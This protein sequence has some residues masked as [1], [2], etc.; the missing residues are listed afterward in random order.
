[1]PLT[2]VCSLSRRISISACV[3]AAKSKVEK[4][5]GIATPG[6]FRAYFKTP[7]FDRLARA[8]LQYFLAVEEQ[9]ALSVVQRPLAE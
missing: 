2:M 9:N 8:C 7:S 4:G 1:M 5:L 6:R 3:Q